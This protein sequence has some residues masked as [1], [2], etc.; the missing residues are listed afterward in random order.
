MKKVIL[1]IL[2]TVCYN[3]IMLAQSVYHFPKEENFQVYSDCF[4]ELRTIKDKAEARTIRYET[5]FEEF[6][7]GRFCSDCKRPASRI[8]REDHVTYESHIASTKGRYSM[9]ATKAMFDELYRNYMADWNPMKKEYDQKFI[10]CQGKVKIKKEEINTAI[11]NFDAAYNQ[12][13]TSLAKVQDPQK[14]QNLQQQLNNT[15]T[16]FLH[17]KQEAQTQLTNG[18]GDALATTLNN[19]KDQQQQLKI[20]SIDIDIAAK[21]LNIQPNNGSAING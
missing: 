4:N 12:A 17:Y 9:T 1:I 15:R 14:R 16:T 20:L 6:K 5:E 10:D 7:N 2:T 3:S 19:I 8:E 21:P 18:E 13:N 11:T